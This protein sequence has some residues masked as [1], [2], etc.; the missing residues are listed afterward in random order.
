ML[1]LINVL[2][3]LII[4]VKGDVRLDLQTTRSKTQ[5]VCRMFLDHVIQG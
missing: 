4:I 3:S 1:S 2:S 5:V